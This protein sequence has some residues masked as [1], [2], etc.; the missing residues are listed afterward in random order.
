[1]VLSKKKIKNKLLILILFIVLIVL[2]IYINI[3]QMNGVNVDRKEIQEQRMKGYFIEAAK[4]ILKGEGLSCISVR[5]I[6]EQAGY[7]YATLYNY[8]NDVKDLIFECVKDFQTECEKFVDSEKGDCTPGTGRIKAVIKAYMKYFIQYPGIFELFYL[9]R[10]TG[11]VYRKTTIDLI[12]SF[13]DRLCENE[14]N[15]YVNKGILTAEEAAVRKNQLRYAIP[16]LL[17]LYLNRRH[18]ASYSE[19]VKITD[20]L[21][22]SILG[23]E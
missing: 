8:F 12:Y 9:E 6:A 11:T 3:N 17:L 16:G 15:Y 13:P 19:F 23:A 20:D 22:D 10:T 1:M 2:I 18:P 14:W 4:S 21:L 7:S 5:N